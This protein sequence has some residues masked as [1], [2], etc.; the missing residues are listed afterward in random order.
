[1]NTL[2]ATGNNNVVSS[3]PRSLKPLR[4]M[5]QK[6]HPKHGSSGYWSDGET[7]KES[8]CLHRQ[9]C[10]RGSAAVRWISINGA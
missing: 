3:R 10:S 6:A 7:V 8:T 9:E 2:Y 4:T 1:M 5:D